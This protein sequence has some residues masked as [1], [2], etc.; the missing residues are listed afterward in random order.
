MIAIGEIELKSLENKIFLVLSLV[1][2]ILTI[3]IGTSL[4]S[5]NRSAEK[6]I[7]NELLNKN[8]S[9]IVRFIIEELTN[10]YY[11]LGTTTDNSEVNATISNHIIKVCYNRKCKNFNLLRAGPVLEKTIPKYIFYKIELNEALIYSNTKLANYEIEKS[12]LLNERNILRVAVSVDERFWLKKQLEIRESY[13]TVFVASLIF[14]ALISVLFKYLLRLYG[15]KI[16][17]YFGKVFFSQEEFLLKKIWSQ[18]YKRKKEL[19]LNYL[20]MK[21]ANKLVL[22][23]E[24]MAVDESSILSLPCNISLY[25]KNHS[26]KVSI[27]ELKIFFLEMFSLEKNISISIVSQDDTIDFQSKE[28]LYQILNSLFNYLIFCFNKTEN[29]DNTAEIKCYISRGGLN[30]EC[31]GFSALHGNDINMHTINF[32]KNYANV[33]LLSLEQIFSMLEKLEFK[34]EIK[35]ED[36]IS[37][38][39]PQEIDV[40]KQVIKKSANISSVLPFKRKR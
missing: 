28:L 24:C 23:K 35:N 20:F 12:R 18:E 16:Y 36:E 37:L 22:S 5:Y 14:I 13:K 11:Q 8:Y 1:L 15:I 32:F 34:C 26:E 31:K 10:V 9:K 6:Q 27:V 40:S 4:L 38:V 33:F 30:L 29:L 25:Q 39:K 19:E 2:F 17:Q 21:K 3:I 7:K